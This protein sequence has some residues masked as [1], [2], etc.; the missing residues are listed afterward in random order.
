MAQGIGTI[1]T[2]TVLKW[3]PF[4]SAIDPYAAFLFILIP[5]GLQACFVASLLFDT[6]AKMVASTS[7][8]KA[9]QLKY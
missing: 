9:Y 5:L 7:A 8:P 4:Y 1:T 3:K 6:S 2:T